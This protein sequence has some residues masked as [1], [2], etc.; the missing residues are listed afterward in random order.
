MDTVWIGRN[1]TKHGP[2]PARQVLDAHSNGKLQPTDLLWWQGL[3]GWLALDAGLHRLREQLGL[4]KAP[5]APITASASALG[6]PGT[7]STPSALNVSAEDPLATP[8]RDNAS[9]PAAVQSERVAAATGGA[10]LRPDLVKVDP[11]RAPAATLA[12]PHDPSQPLAYAGF[13]V[14]FG[15]FVL[16]T[17]VVAFAGFVLGSAIG[18]ALVTGVGQ[19]A[20]L[21]VASQLGGVLIGWLYYALFESGN[22]RATP[23]KM[24]FRLQVVHADTSERISFLRATGRFFGKI[25]SG[26]LLGIGYLMQPFT[27]RKQALHDLLSSAAVVETGPYSRVLLWVCLF[28]AFVPIFFGLIGIAFLLVGFAG[29][30]LRFFT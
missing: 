7:P 6:T 27:A 10:A 20:A 3:E 29:P 16:D 8:A 22:A 13:G 26:M 19:N 9:A 15:A 17:L 21:V 4:S 14:R 30:L 28:I 24:A 1:G 18:F 12:D 2:Y 25:L 11:Y 5:D 23:G